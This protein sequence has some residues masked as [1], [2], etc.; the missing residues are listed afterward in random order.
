MILAGSLPVPVILVVGGGA[1][2]TLFGVHLVRALRGSGLRAR[3]VLLDRDGRHGLGQAY[4][5]PDPRHLLNAP[6]GRMSALADTPEHLLDWARHELGPTEPT[7]FLARAD[8]GRYLLTMLADAERRGAPT[9]TLVRE[10]G[11]AVAA[12]AAHLDRPAGVVLA[13]GRRLEADF[14]VLATGNPPPVAIEG[15]P[16]PGL[17]GDPWAPGVLGEIAECRRV[18]V[19]GTGLTM[20]D[21]AVSVAQGRPGAV[22][23]AVSRRG[24]VPRAHREDPRGELPA[25]PELKLPTGPTRL[26]ALIAAVRVEI[27]RAGG[28]W[29]GVLDAM[30]P[31]L[32]GL[33]AGLPA[34]D[35]ARFVAQLA[36]IWE[37]HRHRLPPATA[38]AVARLRATGRLQ[39]HQGRLVSAELLSDGGRRVVLDTAQGLRRLDVDVIV[40]GTGPGSP[41]S[42]TDPLTVGLLRAG[43]ARSDHLGLGL[44]VTEHGSVRDGA[45]RSQS[46]LAALGPPL[47]GVRWETTAIPEI[48]DQAATLAERVREQLAQRAETSRPR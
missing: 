19:V 31:L 25:L 48:R 22:V 6:A 2:G 24:L 7:D 20:V 39:V 44:D 29:R 13:D 17:V 14:V 4:A 3:I 46:W 30:R 41:A 38:T 21:L 27:D 1:S 9:V 10:T 35:Q 5:T 36:R 34:S 43:L 8:Y 11:S 37:V 32:P 15:P 12:R 18:L 16:G 42:S 47:R 23:H 33:W 40:N 28:D 45:G 26:G